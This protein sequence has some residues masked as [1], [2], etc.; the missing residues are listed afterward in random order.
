L[1]PRTLLRACQR[2][3]LAIEIGNLLLDGRFPIPQKGSAILVTHR[4]AA[5]AA[6][7]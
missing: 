3:R 2:H 5:S 7:G 4:A 6:K 1:A